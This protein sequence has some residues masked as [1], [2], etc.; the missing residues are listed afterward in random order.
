MAILSKKPKVIVGF[1]IN[2]RKYVDDPVGL[3]YAFA[4]AL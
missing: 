1:Q 3:I 4:S 2:V